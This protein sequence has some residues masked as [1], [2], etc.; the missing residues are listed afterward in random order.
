MLLC[1]FQNIKKL[2]KI[3]FSNGPVSMMVHRVGC[4]LLLDDFDIHKNLLR[5]QQDDFH[6][7]RQ[8]Y[9]ETVL[10]SVQHQVL[11]IIE[12]VC[13]VKGLGSKYRTMCILSYGLLNAYFEL[14]QPWERVGW[15]ANK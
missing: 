7:L 8:F 3:P 9:Y 14:E 6:W 10:S 15:T 5:K 12:Q 4:T 2:L 13:T 11:R 1:V